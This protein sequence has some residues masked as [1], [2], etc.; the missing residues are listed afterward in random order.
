MA[1]SSPEALRNAE[2]SDLDN[3]NIS[4]TSE[5]RIEEEAPSIPDYMDQEDMP[6]TR[7]IFQW[8]EED[9]DWSIEEATRF[10]N[11][12]GGT[13]RCHFC[14]FTCQPNPCKLQPCDE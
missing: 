6:A 10:H 13:C 7:Y 9:I 14:D 5:T 11:E 4:V 8:N 3:L 1:P 12:M 2:R